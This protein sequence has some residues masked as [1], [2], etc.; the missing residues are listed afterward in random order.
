MSKWNDFVASNKKYVAIVEDNIAVSA[1]TLFD[2]LGEISAYRTRYFGGVYVPRVQ[3]PQ[4]SSNPAAVEQIN[5][6]WDKIMDAYD[7]EQND[8]LMPPREFR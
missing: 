8:Q 1:D 5:A 4:L 2:L 3:N 7:P 6:V